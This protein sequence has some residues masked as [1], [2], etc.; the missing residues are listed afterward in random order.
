MLNE[1]EELCLLSSEKGEGTMIHLS[2][3]TQGHPGIRSAERMV[4]RGLTGALCD[5]VPLPFRNR[6]SGRVRNENRPDIR[7][8]VRPDRSHRA[9]LECRMTRERR[10]VPRST[11]YFAQY[12]WRERLP[13]IWDT[14]FCHWAVLFWFARRTSIWWIHRPSVCRDPWGRIELWNRDGTATSW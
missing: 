9:R 1:P 12:N 11:L 8:D 13:S 7:A 3:H 5:V 10:L 2:R 4:Q 14:T 6:N